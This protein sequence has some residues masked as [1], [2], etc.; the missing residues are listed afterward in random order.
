[1]LNTKC[2]CNDAISHIETKYLHCSCSNIAY[3]DDYGTHSFL[4]KTNN[5]W[6][7]AKNEMDRVC[8]VYILK[9][10]NETCLRSIEQTKDRKHQIS[11]TKS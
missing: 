11:T 1:M 10:T 8:S 5:N 7:F 4:R 3:E 6:Q 2:E 9:E